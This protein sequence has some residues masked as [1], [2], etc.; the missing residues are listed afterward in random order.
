MSDKEFW[1]KITC[2]TWRQWLSF[3][4]CFLRLLLDLFTQMSDV[5]HNPTLPDTKREGGAR[6]CSPL[7][8]NVLIS[9]I[10]SLS[11]SELPLCSSDPYDTSSGSLQL[12]SIKPMAAQTNYSCAASFERS[13][14]STAIVN[15]E[16]MHTA[17][18]HMYVWVT[19]THTHMYV[20]FHAR[21]TA[22]TVRCP[23]CS[24]G[25]TNAVCAHL[26]IL[27]AWID[28]G[29]GFLPAL[30]ESPNPQRPEEADYFIQSFAS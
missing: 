27:T 28:W 25:T 17:H 20:L 6:V 23:H 13:R 14:D 21:V 15:G 3:G 18:T 11:V 12:I 4:I 29:W 1:W 10:C 30:S 5:W 19:Q 24:C 9:G 26:A 8:D 2:K 22:P 16:V 7:T